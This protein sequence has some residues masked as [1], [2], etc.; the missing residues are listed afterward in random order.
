MACFLVSGCFTVF[1]D[2]FKLG[3]GGGCAALFGF[4]S[5]APERRTQSELLRKGKWVED[6][7]AAGGPSGAGTPQCRP[8]FQTDFDS[9]ALESWLVTLGCVLPAAAPSHLLQSSALPTTPL[10]CASHSAILGLQ[11]RTPRLLLSRHPQCGRGDSAGPVC[12]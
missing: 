12:P 3:D 10:P 7:W 4:V 8:M 2:F 6:G 5:C 1:G 9:G 11:G